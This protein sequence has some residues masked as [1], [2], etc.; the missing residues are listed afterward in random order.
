MQRPI[1]VGV[2]DAI[3]TLSGHVTTFTEKRAAEQAVLRIHGVRALANELEVKLPTDNSRADEDIARAAASIFAWNSSIPKDGIKV[4]VSH[5]WIT[6]EGSVDWHY[7]RQA[8]ELAAEDLM[9]VKGVTN[10]LTVTSASL[11]KEVK[12]QIE[13]ALRRS[14]EL[15]AQRIHVAIEEN[16]VILSGTV[17]SMA[18]KI[19][20]ERATWKAWGV[21]WIENL[22]KVAPADK[23]LTAA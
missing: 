4:Q 2:T 3:V 11:H 10:R 19:A 18:E 9:G 17:N 12:S 5:G 15:D 13:S 23:T 21:G 6:L 16:K 7:Q 14:A 1:G 8:A 20:A 22:I